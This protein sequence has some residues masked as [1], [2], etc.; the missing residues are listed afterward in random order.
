MK[1]LSHVSKFALALAVASSG[2]V[3]NQDSPA[4][5]A[6]APAATAAAAPPASLAQRLEQASRKVDVG[7]GAKVASDLA[8]LRNDPAAT[9]EQRDQASLDLSRALEAQGDE[10]AAIQTLV[11]LV[12]RRG[13]ERNWP[14]QKPAEAALRRLLTGS[15]AGPQNAPPRDLDPT[16]PFARQLVK[17]FAEDHGTIH[18][19]VEGFGG[20]DRASSRIGTF[21]IARAIREAREIE[22]PL[23]DTNLNIWTSQSRSDDWLGILRSGTERQHSV[24]V[25]YYAAGARRIPAY[26]DNELPMPAAEIDARI[27]RGEGVVAAKER[28]GSPPAILIAA[29]RA[30]QLDEVEVALSQMKT[31]PLDPVTVSVSDQLRPEEIEQV[32][33]D[34]RKAQRACYSALLERSPGA[35]GNIKLKLSV[36]EDGSVS[37][38]SS[39]PSANVKDPEFV[40]C[41]EDVARA[42]VFPATAHTGRIVFPVRLATSK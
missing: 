32:V 11:D 4:D 28:P 14:L 23:C 20:S 42:L 7:D 33:R 16:T 31:L 26:F 5:G 36:A 15:E 35:E 13:S 37:E 9:P 27:A 39:E 12:S 38:V 1:T 2:C 3:A 10:G 18:V 29:P 24:A 25:Y 8:A 34:S 19:V 21:N 6:E 41:M 30:A 40:G 17:Y 22:C